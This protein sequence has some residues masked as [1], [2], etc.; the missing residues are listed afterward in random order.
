[1]STCP[2]HDEMSELLAGWLYDALPEDQAEDVRTHLDA[3]PECR[4]EA[5]RLKAR[6]ALMDAWVEDEAPPPT[7]VASTM[8]RIHASEPT[9]WRRR[10]RSLRDRG[11]SLLEFGM[12]D[13]S[14]LGMGIRAVGSPFG[15]LAWKAALACVVVLGVGGYGW[16][17]ERAFH[18]D[19]QGVLVVAPD[20]LQA[21][22][23]GSLRL[24]VRDHETGRLV[25][26]AQVEIDLEATETGRLVRLFVGRT[27]PGGTVDAGFA[28]P[29]LPSGSYRLRVRCVSGSGEDVVT[30]T[31]EVTRTWRML[32]SSD[33]PV[34]QPGQVIHMRT[35]ALSVAGN[36][37]AEKG[38][39]TFEVEDPKGNKVFKKAVPVG[40]FGVASADFE[41]ARE[42]ALGEY[43]VRALLDRDRTERVVQVKKYALPKFKVTFEPARRVWLPSEK[44]TGTVDGQYFFGK[45]VVGARV[46]MD[47]STFDVTFRRVGHVEG[48]TDAGGRYRFEIP[49]PDHFVGQP[50]AKGQAVVKFDV[51][52]VDGAGHEEKISDILHVAPKLPETGPPTVPEAGKPAGTL[53]ITIDCLPERRRPLAG[54]ENQFFVMTTLPGGT[55]VSCDVAVVVD[56]QRST[57]RTDGMGI[58]RFAVMPTGPRVE[59]RVE[60]SRGREARGQG[61]FAFGTE[62]QGNEVLLRTDRSVY[63]VGDP[64]KIAVVTSPGRQGRKAVGGTVYVDLVREGQAI[65]TKSLELRDARAEMVLNLPD[66]AAGTLRVRAW[67]IALDGTVFADERTVIVRAASDLQ[68]TVK[69]ERSTYRPGEA[70]KVALQVTD[71]SGKPVA[72]ALGLTVAD[73]SVFALAEKHPGL[74]KVYFALEESLLKPRLEVCRHNRDLEMPRLVEGGATGYDPQLAAQVVLAAASETPRGL[75]LLD[76]WLEKHVK[77]EDLRR[78]I[79]SEVYAFLLVLV[80]CAC[81]YLVMRLPLDGFMRAWLYLT[82]FASIGVFALLVNRQFGPWWDA[83][84]AALIF[85]LALAVLL[86]PLACAGR[87]I[88]RHGSMAAGLCWLLAQGMALAVLGHLGALRFRH[89]D[90]LLV[91]VVA[92]VLVCTIL[93]LIACAVLSW[94]AIRHTYCPVLLVMAVAGW[95]GLS[96]AA[97]PEWIFAWLGAGAIAWLWLMV[98][99]LE[100]NPLESRAPL[101]AVAL[102]IVIGLILI[103]PRLWD[104]ASIGKMS[105]STRARAQGTL[106]ACKSNLKN[107]GTALE[108]YSTD[109]GGRFPTSLAQL[110]PNY[111]KVI[112]TCPN[113]G[114][115]TYSA[116]YRSSIDPDDYMVC[117]SGDNHRGQGLQANQPSYSATSGLIPGE[118]LMAEQQLAR[119]IS[120]D[121]GGVRDL[122]MN[123]RILYADRRL[124]APPAATDDGIRIRQFFPETLYWNPLVLT[125]ASGAAEVE[126]PGA[127]S[128]TKWRISAL[129]SSKDGMVGSALSPLRV[130]QPFFIDPDLPAELTRGDRVQV[131]VAVYNYLPEPQTLRI[132]LKSEAW[133]RIEGG[134]TRTIT[135]RPNDVTSVSFT[136]H[137]DHVGDHR[138]TVIARSARVQDAISRPIRVAPDGRET[139]DTQNGRLAGSARHVVTIPADAVPGG[140]TILV[141]LYPGPLTQVLD[142]LDGMLQMPYGCFE[143]TSSTTYP[144]VMVL[145]Y[146]KETGRTSPQVQMKAERLINLGYQRLLSFE[147]AGGGF[148]WFGHP[149]A[150]RILT[151]YGLLEFRDMSR[152]FPID[153]SV[154]SRTQ[155]WLERQQQSDGS[156]LPEHHALHDVRHGDNDRVLSTAY[157]AWALAESGDRGRCIQ[158]A[159]AWLKEHAPA[160][161][162]P[163]TL[164][165]I[166]NVLVLVDKGGQDTS[167]VLARLA[168]MA[169]RS[170]R[171]VSWSC[172][173]SAVYGSGRS[174]QVE[175]T[176]LAVQ[177]LARAGSDPALVAGGL[178][179]LTASRSSSGTWDSTQA[180]V[181][182]LRALVETAALAS[183]QSG[184]VHVKI[185]GR[186]HDTLAITP[187]TADVLRMVDLRDAASPGRHVVELVAEG[188]IGMPYQ[189]IGKSYRPW[190]TRAPR[191]EPGLGIR[192]A[193]DRTSL[194]TD[195]MVTATATIDRTGSGESPMIIADLG[196]PPGF[197]VLT[198]DFDE[199]KTR[200]TIARYELR[201]RQVTVY[202]RAVK[203]GSP[204]RLTWRLKARFPIRAQTAPSSVY[205]YYNPSV[206]AEVAPVRFTVTSATR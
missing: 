107:I 111:L 122:A 185:D 16:R 130:F 152:V 56:G 186:L 183:T 133:F 131:P 187:E 191:A 3:C 85:G 201:G 21:A 162:D 178:E 39:L 153:E 150:N 128:I 168:E 179:F 2:R 177:A 62:D 192:V 22:A 113:A 100:I 33:K 180:T 165:L 75:A 83:L 202:L 12:R 147:V 37:A 126:I 140:S 203:S 51:A 170:E 87:A 189:V 34:Y 99:P 88:F 197:T 182:A 149:P 173:Q 114:R 53:P 164:A 206:R 174:G 84:A 14:G 91:G 20:R 129:A 142:G 119:V 125:D 134:T 154:I 52:M 81:V 144:N 105:V 101:V 102:L 156:F 103:M 17:V 146:L 181:L 32:L 46:A 166:A 118:A 124:G 59:L 151:A 127:D 65:L 31:V 54:V 108:M 40:A 23:P 42:I 109:H 79:T 199:M 76:S 195:D 44:V 112:P 64:L 92:F 159:T 9:G 13:V 6:L 163:Y 28:V 145:R 93:S 172:R 7:L 157:V 175:A 47:V 18:G 89:V 123:Q 171:K 24:V 36:R 104:R 15:R 148:D 82:V 45:K 106:T 198:R 205:E 26:G 78:Q 137:V 72:A 204:I 77:Q 121:P 58:A 95:L 49:L 35:L 143:Q 30:K 110:T 116:G 1:M 161:T 29:D 50:M 57:G 155:Q 158:R 61:S 139:L 132:D 136:L 138:L 71:S 48:R 160:V 194:S 43:R 115:D 25:D 11:R 5:A 98:R 27:G 80:A 169:S 4:D 66:D 200:G 196:V 41:L 38:T 90:D 10:L 55:P 69:P 188:D 74:E 167:R 190:G 135:L 117:C 96:L 176:A 70:A 184:K 141:K 94:R 97:N 120:M 193:Y 19:R 8:Q 67:R 60:A 86:Y 73:E 68:V 63:R